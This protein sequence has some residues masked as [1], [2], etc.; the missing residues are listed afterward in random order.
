MIYIAIII[1]FILESIFSIVIPKSS[2]LIPLFVITALSMLYPYFKNK[3]LNYIIICMICGLIYDIIFTS[4]LFINTISFGLSSVFIIVIYNYIHYN[5]YSS[6]IIN[7]INI[8]F[9]RIISYLIY[10]MVL[11]VNFSNYILFTGVYSSIIFNIVYG[12]VFFVIIE[13]ISKLCNIKRTE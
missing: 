7:V 1:S 3:N 9:Y 8:I 12:F 5:I 2:L 11:D 13:K 10:T 4:T 6:N